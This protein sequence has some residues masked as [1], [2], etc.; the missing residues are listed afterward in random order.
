MQVVLLKFKILHHFAPEIRT[1]PPAPPPCVRNRY[2]IGD[3]FQ[4]MTD[5]AHEF[6]SL[7]L[8]THSKSWIYRNFMKARQHQKLHT[9]PLSIFIYLLDVLFII[10]SL[11]ILPG[12]CIIHIIFSLFI[13]SKFLLMGDGFKE[14][15]SKN[16]AFLL[17]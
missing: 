8:G 7:T 3:Y 11:F 9:Q 13:Y 14:L 15:L 1:A 4:S 12:R 16:N 2:F 5:D 6:L 10:F 17:H